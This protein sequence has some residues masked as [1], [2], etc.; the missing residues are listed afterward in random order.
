MFFWLA[1]V[2]VSIVLT[3]VSL[4][5]KEEG[6]RRQRGATFTMSRSL[7]YAAL[8]V[9]LICLSMAGGVYYFSGTHP[10]SDALPPLTV[11]G[12]SALCSLIWSAYAVRLGTS[13]ISVGLFGTRLVSYGSIAR[14]VEIRNQGAPRAV[15]VTTDGKKIGIWSNLIGFDAL[16]R[17][18]SARCPS[19]IHEL[20]EKP[21]ERFRQ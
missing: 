8:A 10:R 2:V 19:A 20:I 6:E 11:A 16:V 14:I 13:A 21:G 12:A 17:Q 15:L 18:L 7:I 4:L 9:S 5:S 3:V 1:P